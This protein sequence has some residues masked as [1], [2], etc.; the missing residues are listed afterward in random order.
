MRLD[1]RQQQAR[2]AQPA[3]QAEEAVW[4][5]I[6]WAFVMGVLSWLLVRM[7]SES[8]YDR[9]RRRFGREAH[10]APGAG[11]DGRDEASGKPAG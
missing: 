8:L 2:R 1:E 3:Q 9:N 7:W 10:L 11:S 4:R 5:L 6:E